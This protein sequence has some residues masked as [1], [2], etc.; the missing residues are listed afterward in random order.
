MREFVF[1]LV[2]TTT[3]TPCGRTR[4]REEL[5]TATV[6]LH[7]ARRSK[8]TADGRRKAVDAFGF[9]KARCSLASVCFFFPPCQLKIQR[10]E[11]RPL[12]CPCDGS[13]GTDSE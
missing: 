8:R 6:R 12:R 2:M 1:Y 11:P 3:T 4:T 10:A 13:S 9:L 5:L 7:R